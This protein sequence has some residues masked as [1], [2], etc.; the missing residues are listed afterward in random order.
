MTAKQVE[1]ILR[2]MVECREYQVQGDCHLGC[3]KCDDCI[4]CYQQGTIGEGTEALKAV[5]EW[6]Q[7]I[8]N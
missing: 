7:F 1:E 2:A 6:I 5:L 3:K 8:L 4:L